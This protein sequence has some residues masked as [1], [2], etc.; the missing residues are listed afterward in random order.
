M[1]KT[2]KSFLYASLVARRRA[3]VWFQVA[4]LK[5]INPALEL[6]VNATPHNRPRIRHARSQSL[7]DELMTAVDDV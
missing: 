4:S 7:T 1:G 5:L 3:G 6:I 2:F